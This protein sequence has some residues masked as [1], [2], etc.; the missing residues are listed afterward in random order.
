[1]VEIN[2]DNNVQFIMTE[3]GEHSFWLR[4][5]WHHNIEENIVL[6]VIFWCEFP[7]SIKILFERLITWRKNKESFS[8]LKLLIYRRR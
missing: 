4:S 8:E 1:M 2:L 7:S 3:E 5:G 6:C